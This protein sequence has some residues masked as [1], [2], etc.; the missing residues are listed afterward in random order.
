MRRTV[1]ALALLGAGGLAVAGE[2]MWVPQQLPEIAG[3]LK[4]RGLQLD[5]NQLA[6]LTG[7]PLGAIVSI[8]GCTAGFVS[9]DG[10]VA[11]NHHCAYGAI[12]LNSTAERDLLKDGFYA[13]SLG[14]ELSA[15][16]NAR[17]FVI[18]Q[19]R[20]VTDQVMAKVTPRLGGAARARA[21]EAAQKALVAECEAE[22]GVRCTVYSFFGGMQYRLFRQLEIRDVRLV[23]APPGA[24]GKYGGDVDNW[25]WP[26]HT[27]DFAFYRAYV[28]PDGKPAAYAE[29][30]VPYRPKRHLRIAAEGLQAGDFAMVA[31]YPGVTFRYALAA[32]FEHNVEWAYPYRIAMLGDLLAIVA[33][34]GERDRDVQIKYASL[35]ASWNNVMKNLTGQLEGFARMDAGTLKRARE[36]AVLDWLKTRGR[37]AR[38]ALDAHAALQRIHAER[39]ASAERDLLLNTFANLGLFDAAK[40]IH[41]NAIEREKPDAERASGYQQRDQATLEGHLRQLERRFDPAVDRALL[42]Y[43]LKRYVLLPADQR[44]PELD[45]WLGGSDAATIDARLATAYAGTELGDTGKRLEWLKADRAAIEASDDAFLQFAVQLTPALL[46]LEEEG[47]R[48]AGEDQRHRPAFLQAVIDYNRSIGQAVYPDAN[49]SLRITFGNVM[50]YSP[51]DAVNYAPFT[52]LQGILEKDTGVDPFDS[53][54]N[55]LDLIRAGAFGGRA[56]AALGSVP[57]NFLTDMDVTGGNSGSPTLNARGELVGLVFDMNW[58]SVSSNWVFNPELTRTIHVDIRYML[59]VMEQV[60]PGPRLLQ[61]MGV[62]AAE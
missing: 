29:D 16:P 25:M 21:I 1:L 50:G 31:G 53:P 19:I 32:E 57:V 38:P 20:D 23:Y 26:R 34:A 36:Q 17:V 5:V 39:R 60:F 3:P 33:A 49:G 7:D 44:L 62:R 37:A 56:S 59:W 14:E 47:R 6:D 22:G 30:N 51:R 58:E 48:L 9:P 24:I 8:G 11:T 10:L 41:R 15:G 61:E 2:G 35:N 45:A 4:A 40:R 55:Q 42:G 54:A 18:D 13:A 52:T 28:G 12:Q 43:L 27:G 46:R